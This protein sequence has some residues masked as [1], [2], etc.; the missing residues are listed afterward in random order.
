VTVTN[1]AKIVEPLS[2]ADAQNA[3]RHVFIHDFVLSARIGVHPHEKQGAQRIRVNIDLAVREIGDEATSDQLAQV[4]CYEQVVAGIR[5]LIAAGH[6]NLVET[7]AEKIAASCLEDRRV[8]VARV[9]IE[10]LDIFADIGS[11]GVEIERF[12]LFSQ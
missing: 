6:V 3:L 2:F 9:R 7:L 4:V 10:K 1:Q 12:S 11:V 8:R 5:S